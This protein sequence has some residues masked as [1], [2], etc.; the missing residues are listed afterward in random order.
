MAARADRAARKAMAQDAAPGRMC[1]GATA[2]APVRLEFEFSEVVSRL[3][4][5]IISLA[6]ACI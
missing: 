4:R 3:Y 2:A 1:L 5:V 6:G